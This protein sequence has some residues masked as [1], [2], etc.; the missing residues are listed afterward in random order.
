MRSEW[1]VC[2]FYRVPGIVR[3]YGRACIKTNDAWLDM[4]ESDVEIIGGS[5]DL[6]R[7]DLNRCGLVTPY[8][9]LSQVYTSLGNGFLPS[10]YY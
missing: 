10:D 9:D 1:L 3:D 5:R 6:W 4:Y 2:V 7:G 8:I